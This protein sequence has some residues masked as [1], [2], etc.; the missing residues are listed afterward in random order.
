MRLDNTVKSYGF[1]QNV[2]ELLVYKHF[3]NEKVVIVI[4]YVDDI[5]FGNDERMLTLVN[6]WLA[7]RFDMKNLGVANFVL[8]I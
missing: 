7:K 2:D 8:G 5:L 3:K 1:Q 6:V 4:L